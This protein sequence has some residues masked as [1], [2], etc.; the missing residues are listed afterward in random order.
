MNSELCP[1]KKQETFLTYRCWWQAVGVAAVGLAFGFCS[2][3]V[4]EDGGWSGGDRYPVTFLQIRPTAPF[5]VR[6]PV[7][8]ASD[9]LKVSCTIKHRRNP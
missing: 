4:G 2:T 8:L 1:P 5:F 6:S 9:I 7:K 3:E